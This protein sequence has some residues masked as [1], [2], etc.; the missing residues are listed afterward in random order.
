MTRKNL[1]RAAVS[2]A[3]LLAATP[4]LA[5]DAAA[6]PEW[7]VAVDTVWVVLAGMMVFFMNAGFGLLETGFCRAKNAVNI[8]AKNFTVAAIAGLAFFFVGFGLM[9]ADGNAFVGLGGLMLGGADNSPMMGDAYQGIFSSLSWAAVPLEAKFFFQACFAMAAASIV[10]GAVAERIKFQ[11]FVVFSL[12]LVAAVY[13]VSG[14]WIWGGGWLANLGFWDFAGSTAVHSVG[15]WAALTGAIIL[16]ARKGKYGKDGSIRPIP[17]HNMALATTGGFI[18]W[19]GWFGFNAGST[20][21][22]DPGAIAHIATTTM[23]ASLAGI[24]GALVAS[25]IKTKAFD[26]SMMING[27]LAGLVAITAPCAFVSATSLVLIG[28][29]AGTIV[30]GGVELF[31]R[32]KVDDP[33]GATSVHLLGGVWGTLALGLFA[34]ARFSADVGNGLFFGGGVSLLG[35]QAIGVVSVAAFVLAASSAIWLG[36]KYTMGLRVDEEEE[37]LGL[38]ITEMRMRAYPQDDLTGMRPIAPPAHEPVR[39]EVGAVETAPEPQPD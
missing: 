28:F 29:A 24:A 39:V 37:F 33:V 10:S 14:H 20:M 3:V 13:G 1:L 6:P 38:D 4:A 12:V 30:V 23:L 17:G 26:L 34:E 19:V 21:A 11:S 35:A 5:D 32:L 22:A 16:G 9:F 27:N 25:Y 31:D 18:L 7:K 8:L 15:G 2:T 36:I